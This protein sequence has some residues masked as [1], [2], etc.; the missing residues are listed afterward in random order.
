[1]ENT[2]TTLPALPEAPETK[3]EKYIISIIIFILA[4]A[5]AYLAWY[6]NGKQKVPIEPVPTLSEYF[7]TQ[8][9][10]EQKS[11]KICI[12]GDMCDYVPS[13]KT[14]EEVCGNFK[15]GWWRAT[16]SDISISAPVSP[17]AEAS[18]GGDIYKQTEDPIK[19]K[20][21]ESVAPVSNP[22]GGAYKNPFE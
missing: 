8:A 22:I 7:S 17:E 4:I 14:F 12:S 21:P 19:D 13:E 1:M 6:V 15:K 3:K 18:L 11:G 5:V 2:T 9:E 16:D 20:I 10:C